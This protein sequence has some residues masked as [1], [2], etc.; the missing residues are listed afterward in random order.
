ITDSMKIEN[1]ARY[2]HR[3]PRGNAVILNSVSSSTGTEKGIIEFDVPVVSGS[4]IVSLTNRTFGTL[5]FSSHSNNGPITYT[6]NGNNRV[7]IRGE[8]LIDSLVSV[9]VGF[10]DTIWVKGNTTHRGN[11]FNLSNNGNPTVLALE[12][13]LFVNAVSTVSETNTAQPVVLFCGRNNQECHVQGSILNEVQ[14]KLQKT[15]SVIL[16]SPLNLPFHLE[17]KRGVFKTD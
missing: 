14:F 15:G 2:I 5:I 12:G 4:Y 9:S 7:L 1:N 6:S 3:C 10:N 17:I 11:L 8:L 16:S 13:N